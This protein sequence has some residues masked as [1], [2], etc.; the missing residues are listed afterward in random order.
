[1]TVPAALA[2]LNAASCPLL[3]QIT[4]NATNAQPLGQQ[5]VAFTSRAAHFTDVMDV[6]FVTHLVER[7]TRLVGKRKDVSRLRH[8]RRPFLTASRV[9]SMNPDR[10]SGGSVCVPA[11]KPGSPC[12]SQLPLQSPHLVDTNGPLRHSGFQPLI[13]CWQLNVSPPPAAVVAG[14][15]LWRG[16]LVLAFHFTGTSGDLEVLKVA[17][18]RARRRPAQR[19]ES[20]FALLCPITHRGGDAR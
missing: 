3:F 13:D 4:V 10:V 6:I 7:L 8:N 11:I 17:A 2:P 15:R 18:L 5:L 9:I 16:L 12:L 19:R 20:I 1:M 14:S